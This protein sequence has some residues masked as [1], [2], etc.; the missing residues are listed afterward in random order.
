MRAASGHTSLDHRPR[1]AR[2]RAR[3]RPRRVQHRAPPSGHRLAKTRRRASRP[4]T[5]DPVRP[6]RRDVP[7]AGGADQAESSEEVMTT[8]AITDHAR[9]L[10]LQRDGACL[11]E[12]VARRH[13]R[14]RNPAR[15]TPRSAL[16]TRANRSRHHAQRWVRKVGRS[17]TNSETPQP[18]APAAGTRTTLP[19]AVIRRWLVDPKPIGA[20]LTDSR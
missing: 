12:V 3:P 16:R 4:R 10:V 17:I 13:R 1:G 6:T 5:R 9:S 11:C 19:V 7:R 14:G 15:F 18:H 20:D 2:G 8:A